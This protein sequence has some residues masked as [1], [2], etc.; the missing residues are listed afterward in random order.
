MAAIR[1]PTDKPGPVSR[2]GEVAAILRDEILSGQ[3]RAGER[4]P[5]E[6][7][8][9]V[10]FDTSRGLVREAFKKL[11]QLGIVSIQPGGARV[12]PITECTLDVLGPLLDL[13]ALADPKLVD[14]VLHMFGVL[15]DVAARTAV[16]KAEQDQIDEAMSICDTMLDPDFDRNTAPD[17]MRSLAV[18]FVDSADHLVLRLILNGLRTTFLERM[19]QLGV[20]TRLDAKTHHAIVRQLRDALA[21]RD[22]PAVGAAMSRLN[23][24]FRARVA[25]ALGGAQSDNVRISA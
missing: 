4:M 14:E 7:D 9:V 12:V 18:L 16:R 21:A 11:E 15:L 13:N 1:P 10:R 6:R 17:T 2:S 25:E 3:Y 22:A 8:L 20:E 24:E 23:R 19:P 5:S